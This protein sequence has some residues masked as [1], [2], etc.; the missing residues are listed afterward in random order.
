VLAIVLE[1]YLLDNMI[2]MLIKCGV[3]LVGKQCRDHPED[4][5][6]NPEPADVLHHVGPAYGIESPEPPVPILPT[7]VVFFALIQ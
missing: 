5:P 2:E 1:L 7:S 3:R 6:E 4:R